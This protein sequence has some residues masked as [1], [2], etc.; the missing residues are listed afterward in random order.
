MPSLMTLIN[1][2]RAQSRSS[3]P[4]PP[5]THTTTTSESTDPHYD[6]MTKRV[7]YETEGGW[8]REK[9]VSIKEIE[10]TLVELM[11]L[12]SHRDQ[13]DG[14]LLP[15][16]FLNQQSLQQRLSIPIHGVTIEDL[17]G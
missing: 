2:G 15:R 7:S 5:H 13:L 16:V 10:I 8:G 9:S 4:P 6:E 14:I 17:E 12:S 11:N 1:G 3:T